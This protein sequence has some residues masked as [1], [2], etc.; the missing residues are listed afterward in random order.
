VALSAAN[1]QDAEQIRVAERPYDAKTLARQVPLRPG[2]ADARAAVMTGLLRAKFAQHPELAEVLAGTGNAR[3]HY[4][5]LAADYWLT[6]GTH[7]RNW[8][9]RLL[10]LV[11]S[12]LAAQR[13]GIPLP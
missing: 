1:L 2:W 3:I 12:E 9:G 13:S 10:E 11:R 7:G 5:G 6:N 4:S 8:M